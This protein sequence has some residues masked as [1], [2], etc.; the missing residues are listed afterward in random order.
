MTMAGTGPDVKPRRPYDAS[1]RRERARLTS[2]RI[3]EVAER[4]FLS[5]GYGVT[6]ADI[7]GEAGVSPDTIYKTFGGKPGLLRAIRTRALEG[8][9]PLP[10][11]SR[12]DELHRQE[13]DPRR[14][15]ECWGRL[16][17]EIAPRVAPILLLVRA[18]AATDAEVRELRRE[19][20][21]DRYRRMS[22]NAAK[23]GEAGHLRAGVT[24]AEAADIL[25]T[26]SSPELYELTV[27]DRGWSLDRYGRFVAEAMIAALL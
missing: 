17:A 14:I 1:R 2:A 18:V 21:E 24:V 27:L 5:E 15:I 3:V 6:I 8:E 20:D 7:A 10:A 26:Y 9:Q 11:E 23:L 22:E 25:W 13:S 19:L 16:T 4:R 12:S